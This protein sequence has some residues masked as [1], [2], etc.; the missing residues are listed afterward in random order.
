MK[1]YRLSMTVGT[2]EDAR[3]VAVEVEANT[4][5]E[6]VAALG[7]RG[8]RVNE[9][10]AT[11]VSPLSA[12]VSGGT[13]YNEWTVNKITPSKAPITTEAAARQI[14][15]MRDKVQDGPDHGV[16]RDDAV[17]V[18]EGM[19]AEQIREVAARGP[20]PAGYQQKNK[21]D[22]VRFTV[23]MQVG[24][25]LN[26]RAIVGYPE[27]GIAPEWTGPAAEERRARM[28]SELSDGGREPEKPDATAAKWVDPQTGSVHVGVI[29]NRTKT[30]ADVEWDN[31]R[32]EKGVKLSDDKIEFLTPEDAETAQAEHEAAQRAAQRDEENAE[33]ARTG[34]VFPQEKDRYEPDP[35]GGDSERKRAAEADMRDTIRDMQGEAG[36]GY[37]VGLKDL[38]EK[39]PDLTKQEFDAAATNVFHHTDVFPNPQRA[40]SGT[41]EEQEEAGIEYGGQ[42]HSVHILSPEEAQRQRADDPQRWKAATR[43]EAESYFATLREEDLRNLARQLDVDTEGNAEELRE[44]LV[45]NAATNHREDGIRV[46]EETADLIALAEAEK[47]M[48]HGA[49]PATWT[50]EERARVG[51]AARRQANNDWEPGRQRAAM[52]EGLPEDGTLGD[53]WTEYAKDYDEIR[54]GKKEARET[55]QSYID[56]VMEGTDPCAAGR[57]HAGP[58]LSGHTSAEHFCALCGGDVDLTDMTTT[59]GGH[60]C[61]RCIADRAAYHGQPHTDWTG[62]PGWVGQKCARC[63]KPMA[64]V[65]GSQHFDADGGASIATYCPRCQV[66]SGVD[67]VWSTGTAPAEDE[68]VCEQCG[69]WPGHS[70]FCPLNGQPDGVLRTAKADDGAV[71]QLVR[72]EHG[73]AV[74]DSVCGHVTSDPDREVLDADFDHHLG[75]HNAEHARE[76]NR[77]KADDS[78]QVERTTTAD[79]GVVITLVRTA[80]AAG[81]EAGE[82]VLFDE[83]HGHVTTGPLE[84]VGRMNVAFDNH[85]ALHNLKHAE[86]AAKPPLQPYQGTKEQLEL[87]Y[88]RIMALHEEM[89]GRLN[90][91]QEQSEEGGREIEQARARVEDI[92]AQDG[93]LRD[94]AAKLMA[95]MEKARFDTASIAG[96]DA[97][98]TA[99]DP[100][101]IAEMIDSVDI[102]S[103]LV[104]QHYN[105]TAEVI[106]ELNQS[107][108][109]LDKTYGA[110]AA[111]IQETG[112][113]GKALEGTGA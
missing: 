71:I 70:E 90:A 56:H 39:F 103:D 97:A 2:G 84:D 34:H 37:Y 57:R 74:K 67:W 88:D 42:T 81:A 16:S 11:Y 94:A 54:E 9:H 46:H 60:L 101:G 21:D 58:C 51:A 32:V 105:R 4:P 28:L 49:H 52:F 44:R 19:T 100:D 47:A 27:K 25:A 29:R 106:E 73:Y 8:V 15:E 79:D 113:S 3:D 77:G 68:N 6:A 18:L 65:K 61:R 12:G 43:D 31:G 82:Y 22:L 93:S 69:Q 53:K 92:E 24:S 1:V 30:T 76:V 107:E 20:L 91:R 96:V 80:S 23:D 83:P 66:S 110:L 40:G 26:H 63:D 14:Q 33:R 72:D 45:D 78:S 7:T 86:A 112:V 108:L 89:I 38:R 55:G 59:I 87:N 102:T 95:E 109:Y 5:D 13:V 64:L 85:V 48:A 104:M 41:K 98:A 99:V 111:G 17:A 62:V 75:W 50:E 10:G 35:F 36:S